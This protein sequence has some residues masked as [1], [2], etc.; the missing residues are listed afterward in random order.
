[1]LD[2]GREAAGDMAAAA[3]AVATAAVRVVETTAAAR[4]GARAAAAIDGRV[5][6]PLRAA[7]RY[8]EYQMII[9]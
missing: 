7:A 4:A 9:C 5:P 2:S 1:M 6:R 8:F 3:M